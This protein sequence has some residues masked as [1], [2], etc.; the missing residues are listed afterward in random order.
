MLIRRS[1]RKVGSGYCKTATVITSIARYSEGVLMRQPHATLVGG[2]Q[3]M[4]RL[5][6]GPTYDG[7][8]GAG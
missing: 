5:M 8:V 4:E 1:S 3:P 2:K 6:V 7:V